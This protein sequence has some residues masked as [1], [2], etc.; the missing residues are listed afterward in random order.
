MRS[1]DPSSRV[2]GGARACARV[3]AMEAVE[4]VTLWNALGI[5]RCRVCVRG[6]EEG[7][8]GAVVEGG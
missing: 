4:E 3:E 8:D 6:F 7:R 1:R 5:A 2:E